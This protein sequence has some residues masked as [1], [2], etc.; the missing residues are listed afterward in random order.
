MNKRSLLVI[1]CAFF[2]ALNI[3]ATDTLKVRS[4]FIE[5]DSKSTLFKVGLN[6]STKY[7][8]GLLYVKPIS[9]K[10]ERIIFLSELG[11]KYFDFEHNKITNE[12]TVKYAMEYLNKKSLISLLKN[13]LLFLLND[14]DIVEKRLKSDGVEIIK[15]T[16]N[17]F[18]RKINSDSSLKIVERGF[19]W[20]RRI[21]EIDGASATL[22]HKSIIRIKLQLR[23]I[24]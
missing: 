3:S 13:D 10:S 9:D 5:Q 7:F 24:K 15:T 19:L 23:R 12:I 1:V 20:P 11:L 4:K 22:Y 21:L 17:K 14:Y 6:I 18:K 8:G 16:S 2:V